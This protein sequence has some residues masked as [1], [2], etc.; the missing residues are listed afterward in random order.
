MEQ[1]WYTFKNVEVLEME[2]ATSWL[3]VKHADNLV[4]DAAKLKYKHIT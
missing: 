2:P 1:S 4:N 3:G